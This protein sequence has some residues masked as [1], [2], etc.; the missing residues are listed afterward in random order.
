MRLSPF[1]FSPN[2]S[3]CRT[4]FGM[5]E[6][7]VDLFFRASYA[8][9]HK[10]NMMP[11]RYVS[12][13]VKSSS[14]KRNKKQSTKKKKS[15]GGALNKL[16]LDEEYTNPPDSMISHTIKLFSPKE[17]LHPP[18][19]RR[20]ESPTS[21]PMRVM[22]TPSPKKRFRRRKQQPVEDLNRGEVKR[23]MGIRT[24]YV[25]KLKAFVYPSAAP[26]G[27]VDELGPPRRFSLEERR[28]FMALLVAYRNLTLK[29][30][31]LFRDKESLSLTASEEE[32]LEQYL[33]DMATSID[34]MSVPEVVEWLCIDPA[35]NPFLCYYNLSGCWVVKEAQLVKEFD[36]KVTVILE[37]KKKLGYIGV[38]KPEL[39]PA[40][41]T[42]PSELALSPDVLQ[43][44]VELGAIVWRLFFGE[45]EE[46]A[47]RLND[48]HTN[49][50]GVKGVLIDMADDLNVSGA[51]LA[52]INFFF[53]VWKQ[54]V[55]VVQ[56]I[57][58][59]M[60]N[61]RLQTKRR[62]MN[63]FQVWANRSYGFRAL[64]VRINERQKVQV[65]KAWMV[66][67]TWCRQF[68][69]ILSR[70]SRRRLVR[71]FHAWTRFEKTFRE[72]RDF[73]RN[74]NNRVLR[75]M[76]QHIKYFVVLKHHAMKY[77]LRTA[78]GRTFLENFQR[79][80]HFK[81]WKRT[82]SL[83]TRLRRLDAALVQGQIKRSM[84]IWI[85]SIWPPKPKVPLAIRIRQLRDVATQHAQ[86]AYNHISVVAGTAKRGSIA[87]A[88]KSKHYI[89]SSEVARIATG[90]P[91]YSKGEL[92]VF[93]KQREDQRKNRVRAAKKAIKGNVV[94]IEVRDGHS[95]YD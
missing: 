86:K 69:N 64:Q 22:R 95:D 4:N 61:R 3:R 13:T 77:R 90:R 68:N 75:T 63:G 19:G 23:L 43:D 15:R 62:V 52:D 58:G 57:K 44:C 9:I 47:G 48:R 8:P 37:A 59:I 85:E 31:K 41:T 5:D 92:Q 50:D 66:Y 6:D 30:A 70:V 83:G 12:E 11:Q 72:K 14:S 18:R 87:A 81:S 34:W 25:E 67:L 60:E 94:K 80:K 54:K 7:E 56:K 26:G 55:A 65:F 46:L 32:N 35:E 88:I 33:G 53:G 28:I 17:T 24:T 78:S 93:H 45:V 74:K 38:Q 36:A 91:K 76:L 16:L 49:I 27:D 21:V 84:H 40:V 20:G 29:I 73:M 79:H 42:V 39:H 71:F 10:E 2:V 89:M 51:P 82:V 1:S